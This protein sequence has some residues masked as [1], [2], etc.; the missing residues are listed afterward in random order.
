M[1][2]RKIIEENRREG[3]PIAL[4][5]ARQKLE[6]EFKETCKNNSISSKRAVKIFESRS[7][8]KETKQI[9]D[10]LDAIGWKNVGQHKLDNRPK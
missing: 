10:A 5:E 3:D 4:E 7:N 1:S 2:I 6:H 9:K 8:S